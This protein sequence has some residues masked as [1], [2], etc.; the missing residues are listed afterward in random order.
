MNLDVDVHIYEQEEMP[1][2]IILFNV[3]INFLIVYCT[4]KTPPSSKETSLNFPTI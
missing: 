3:D 1:A 4:I 2:R